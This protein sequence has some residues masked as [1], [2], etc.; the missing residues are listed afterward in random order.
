MP[1]DRTGK[2]I[3]WREPE[4]RRWKEAASQRNYKAAGLKDLIIAIYMYKVGQK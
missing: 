3:V 2:V 4:Y 1:N